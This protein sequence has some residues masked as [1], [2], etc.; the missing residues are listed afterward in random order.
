MVGI[1]YTDVHPLRYVFVPWI[2]TIP[3]TLE[4]FLWRMTSDD[5][6][7]ILPDDLS[8]L[9]YSQIKA[10]LRMTVEFPETV[11]IMFY[12]DTEVQKVRQ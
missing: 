2:R 4:T 10:T 7:A 5:K 12:H 9:I 3:D 8:S 6:C 1:T 11:L